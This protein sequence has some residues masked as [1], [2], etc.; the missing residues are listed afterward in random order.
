M[1]P[2]NNLFGRIKA[3]L[4]L[5]PLWLLASCSTDVNPNVTVSLSTPEQRVGRAQIKMTV[6][7]MRDL[8]NGTQLAFAFLED[9]A[10][11]T[12]GVARSG[13]SLKTVENG[14]RVFEIGSLTKVF[15]AALLAHMAE[16]GTVRLDQSISEHLDVPFN[17][18]ANLTIEGDADIRFLELANHTAGLPRIPSSLGWATIFHASNPYKNYDE[19]RLREYLTAEMRLHT[20]PGS[21]F[22]YSNLGA[23]LLGYVLAEA[24]DA[25]YEQLLRKYLFGP[26][27]MDHSTTDRSRVADRL[28]VGR[29]KYGN[30][31]PNWDLAALKGAGAILSTTED[32][33]KFGIANFDTT[34]SV[35][36]MIQKETFR[37]DEQTAVGLGWFI[38]NRES[39]DRWHWHNGGTGGYRSSM[40]LDIGDARGVAI[41]SNVSAGHPEAARIDSLGF[42]LLESM[43]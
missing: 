15:T 22:Q 34:N 27:E 10:A 41:L 4:P 26:L 42:S 6:P 7:L 11:A 18:D 19:A 29:N 13:D 36:R 23:G 3:L 35:F 30:P 16:R 31:T 2:R 9:T 28:V 8:P 38:L 39:G 43:Q 1:I 40:V 12:Y 14:D 37:I 24:A 21:S 32:L 25:S 17:E 20:S 33:A 5:L